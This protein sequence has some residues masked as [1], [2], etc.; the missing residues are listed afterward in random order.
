M[1]EFDFK[2]AK[3]IAKHLYHFASPKPGGSVMEIKF[4]R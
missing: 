2:H 3:M 4:Y 1:V